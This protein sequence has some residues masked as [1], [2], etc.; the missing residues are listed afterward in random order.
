LA[1]D[2]LSWFLFANTTQRVPHAGVIKSVRVVNFMNHQHFSFD[3]FG[4]KINFIVGHNGSGKSA[5]LTAI[6]VA[7]GARASV[8]GRGSGVKDLIRRGAE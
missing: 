4:R 6:A 1:L 2:I 3:N 8:T 5:I 7:L